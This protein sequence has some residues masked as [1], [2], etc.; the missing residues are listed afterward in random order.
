MCHRL[1]NFIEKAGRAGVTRVFIG[2]ESINPTLLGAAKKAEQHHRISQDDADVE[3]GGRHHL[4]PATFSAFPT[5]TP[6]SL[7][8]DIEIIKR[9]LPIDLLEFYFLTPLPGSEDHQKLY[10]AG[11][12]LDPDLNKYDLEHVTTTQRSDV[13]RAV[14][15]ASIRKAWAAFYYSP[16]HMDPHNAPRARPPASVPATCCS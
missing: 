8:R 10:K 16:E 13:A 4:L 5:D 3:K 15:E 2:L 11:A 7:L 1:P 12:S 14:G 6:E 9:E